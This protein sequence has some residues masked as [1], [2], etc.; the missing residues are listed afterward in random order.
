MN[1]SLL[2][3]V[4]KSVKFPTNEFKSLMLLCSRAFLSCCFAYFRHWRAGFFS[5]FKLFFFGIALPLVFC[6]EDFFFLREGN[7]LRGKIINSPEHVAPYK[8]EEVPKNDQFSKMSSTS[9]AERVAA[10]GV[11]STREKAADWHL[12][13]FCCC[14]FSSLVSHLLPLIERYINCETVKQVK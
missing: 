6:A 10:A 9:H 5:L 1:N 7:K 4:V 2:E 12:S 11:D 14:F 13:I 8:T 3:R